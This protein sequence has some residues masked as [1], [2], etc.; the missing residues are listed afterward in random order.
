VSHRNNFDL[1]RFAFAFTYFAIIV[2][3][4]VLDV[5]I[6]ILPPAEYLSGGVAAYLAANLRRNSH[7]VLAEAGRA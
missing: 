6:T 1:L 5:L 2:G 3:C 4:A 7:Y